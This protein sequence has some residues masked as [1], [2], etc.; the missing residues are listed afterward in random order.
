MEKDPVVIA[1]IARTPMG[2]FQGTLSSVAGPDLGSVAIKSSLERA[3]IDPGVISEVIM[4]CVLPAGQGQA[5]ARQAAINA[6]I[7]VA[8]GATTINKMCGSGMKA[9]MFG[10]DLVVAGSANI[11]VVGGLESMSNTPYLLP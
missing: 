7:P 6:G 3:N 2:S 8:V 11:A 10:H 1:S 9:T 4:G 5:P